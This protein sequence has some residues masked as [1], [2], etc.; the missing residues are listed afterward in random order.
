[1]DCSASRWR[2]VTTP[3]PSDVGRTGVTRVGRPARRGSGRLSV[4]GRSDAGT[5]AVNLRCV[6]LRGTSRTGRGRAQ[7]RCDQRCVNLSGLRHVDGERTPALRVDAVMVFLSP[8]RFWWW[9]RRCRVGCAA[10][11]GMHGAAAARPF[12]RPCQGVRVGDRCAVVVA[13]VDLAG[14]AFRSGDCPGVGRFLAA[15]VTCAHLNNLSRHDRQ[16]IRPPNPP[17][18][19]PAATTAGRGRR[20]STARIAARSG[21]VPARFWR[22]LA[23]RYSATTVRVSLARR[24]CCGRW[25]P[26]GRRQ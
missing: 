24:R 6:N 14:G 21:W 13:Q 11:R 23:V 2:P 18:G 5:T 17:P 1:M 22:Q 26:G 8:Y 4:P 12:R 9:G 10:G 19:T 15:S 3:A 7:G 25:W 16:A 20:R